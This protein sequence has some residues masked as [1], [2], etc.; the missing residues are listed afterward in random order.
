MALAKDDLDRASTY[1][2][3]LQAGGAPRGF[4]AF[5]ALPVMLARAA[6]RALEE[7]GPGA[8][9]PRTEVA[10]LMGVLDTTLETGAPLQQATA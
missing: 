6:L 5:T 2:S 10:R 7:K 9:V 3:A 1:V 4:L 8:K